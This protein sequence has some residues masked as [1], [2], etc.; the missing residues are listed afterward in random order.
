LVIR[1]SLDEER[2]GEVLGKRSAERTA[3]LL[4]YD[5]R[6]GWP[7]FVDG[8]GGEGHSLRWV[9]EVI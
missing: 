1:A 8:G 7:A 9:P 4:V 3:L 5:T 6:S 2:K